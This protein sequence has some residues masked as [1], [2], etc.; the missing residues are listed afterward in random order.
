MPLQHW[1]SRWLAP[2]AFDAVLLQ[3]SSSASGQQGR[4]PRVTLLLAS[5]STVGIIPRFSDQALPMANAPKSKKAPVISL[6]NARAT[7]DREA[8]FARVA[9]H[10]GLL[11]IN[12]ANFIAHQDGTLEL[13][14]PGK[15]WWHRLSAAFGVPRLP[16]T[17]AEAL[18]TQQ[19]LQFLV[20]AAKPTRYPEADS[21]WL[22]AGRR[23]IAETMPWAVDWFQAYLEHDVSRMRQV[24]ADEEFMSRAAEDWLA[25][26]SSDGPNEGR[27][28]S[29]T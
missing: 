29:H 22:L 25:A 7:I 21:D 17:E 19:A 27:S 9:E 14:P 1:L 6:A 8:R 13:L 2:P 18:G 4:S 23:T 28:S 16:T 10:K 3:D 5:P 20:G 11:E 26:I 12:V 24:M 15:A